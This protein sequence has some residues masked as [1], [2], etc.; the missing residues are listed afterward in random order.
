MTNEEPHARAT[1][2]PQIKSDVPEN[3]ENE[4]DV[5]LCESLRE[6]FDDVEQK[7]A[8]DDLEEEETAE[9]TDHVVG[10]LNVVAG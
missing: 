10:S 8:V 2:S 9:K 1:I 7:T 3:D 6:S 4:L 5:F